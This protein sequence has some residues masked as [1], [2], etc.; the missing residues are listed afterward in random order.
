MSSTAKEE[1]AP[2][3]LFSSLPN[4]IVLNILARVPRRYNSILSCVSKQLRFLIRSSELRITRSLLGKDRFY[5]C[6]LEISSITT[7]DHW[8]TFTEDRPCLVSIPFPSP[9]EPFSAILTL[10]PEIYF[11]GGLLEKHV[12]PRLS[13]RKVASRRMQ[14]YPSASVY[15]KTQTWQVAPNPTAKLQCLS[16][17]VVAQSLGRKIYGRDNQNVIIYDTRDGE[18]EKIIPANENY[19]CGVMCVVDNVI[20]MH[21]YCLGLMWFESKEKLWRMVHG[22][23][24]NGHFSSTAMAEH[25]GK[26]AFLW[27]DRNKRELWCAM[28]ALYGS[29][30]VAIHGRVEWSHRLLSHVPSNYFIKYF[31]VCTDY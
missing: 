23:E 7:S 24:L 18:C 17:Y 14:R 2:S 30:Q 8:S 15:L 29:S 1:E 4:D 21:Y 22:L 28:I 12:D 25:N 13:V 10:G 5:V 31:M 16:K 3:I 20:Y 9:P 6:F 19:K 27:H 11:Y 26:M